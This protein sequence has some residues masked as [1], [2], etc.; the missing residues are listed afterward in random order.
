MYDPSRADRSRPPPRGSTTKPPNP[1]GGGG[2]VSSVPM[3]RAPSRGRGALANIDAAGHGS[4]VSAPPQAN[5]VM[6]DG[7]PNF[8]H[9]RPISLNCKREAHVTGSRCLEPGEHTSPPKARASRQLGLRERQETA[10]QTLGRP[11]RPEGWLS[12]PGGEPVRAHQTTGCQ[13]GH[14]T[15]APT[16]HSSTIDTRPTQ[17]PLLLVHL[18]RRAVGEAAGPGPGRRPCVEMLRPTKSMAKAWHR[19]K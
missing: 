3:L 6:S 13:E 7:S 10:T 11:D 18:A 4:R 1:G 12:G 17:R 15:V 16:A 8:T 19:P 14:D 5:E 9:S 2:A